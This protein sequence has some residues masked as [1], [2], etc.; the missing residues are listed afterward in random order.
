MKIEKPHITISENDEIVFEWWNNDKKLTIY[1]GNE[2]EYL[3]VK[4][5]YDITNGILNK[6]ENL[7]ELFEWLYQ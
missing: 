6:D 7:K 4:N 2:I 3:K 1:F 5:V